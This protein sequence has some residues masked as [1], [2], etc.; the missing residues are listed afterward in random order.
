MPVVLR[1]VAAHEIVVLQPEAHRVEQQVTPR[2]G[3]IADV[4]VEQLAQR[5]RRAIDRGQLL[6]VAWRRWWLLAQQLRPHE[7][8]P[9]CR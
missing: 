3:W 6:H 9:L 8:A 4:L 7:L 1:P 2:T 5:L